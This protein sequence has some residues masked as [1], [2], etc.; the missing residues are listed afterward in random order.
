MHMKR[1][2]PLS[3]VLVISLFLEAMSEF[4]RLLKGLTITQSEC[5][6]LFMNYAKEA[7]K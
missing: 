4:E 1:I 3:H 6:K 5:P 7:T 2:G